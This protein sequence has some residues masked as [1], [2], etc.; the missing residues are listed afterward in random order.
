[1]ATAPPD[2]LAV[3]DALP[4]SVFQFDRDCRI[5]HANRWVCDQLGSTPAEVVGKVCPDLGMPAGVWAEW[6]AALADTLATGRV[7]QYEFVCGGP[8]ERLVEYRFAPQPAADGRPES[9]W[10]VALTITEVQ[11][12]RRALRE[13]EHLF[14]AFLDRVPALAWLRDS[15][16]R[17]AFVNQ[18]YLTHYGLTADDRI[19]KTPADV[20]PTE[21]A[22]Q[23]RAN[24]QAVLDSGRDVQVIETVPEPDGG[25][26]HWL[27]VKFP[28]VGE[29]G[30]RYI[31]GIGVDVTEQ[32]AA[33]ERA[34]RT[35]KLESLG[36]LAAGAAHDFNNLLTVVLGQATLALRQVS[37]DS[38]VAD[39]LRQ[40]QD[41][42][43]RAAELC[44]QM[45]SFAGRRKSS[46]VDVDLATIVHDTARLTRGLLPASTG[47]HFD[48]PAHPVTV[49]AD[50]THLRQVVLNLITNAADAMTG[51]AGEVRVGVTVTNG[52]ATLAV[53]D[54]G[55]GMSAEVSSRVFEP[56]FTTKTH[57]H[58]LG[59][60]AVQGLIH[61]MGGEI[62]VHS[63]PGAGSTFR[64]RLPAV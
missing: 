4:V 38:P 24:D 63:V 19:G 32:R 8:E 47:L 55:C 29:S 22:A 13:Q 50:P 21:V 53:S 46:P 3:L 15:A 35:A 34:A 12:L 37:P 45:L 1:M 16:S 51:R 60:A 14:R 36:L 54:Q 18:T 5:V 17:Y 28:F 39:R 25:L 2:S 10:V 40:I 30:E 49:H 33:E 27:N 56:F 26:R 61:S 20:W 48:L 11:L 64:V 44:E 42:G 41:A 31:G 43:E 6:Q 58:G 59:L 52:Q 23:F 9:V 57:G 62:A 7:G